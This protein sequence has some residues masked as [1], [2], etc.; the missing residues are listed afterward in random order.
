MKEKALAAQI[1]LASASPRRLELLEQIGVRVIVRAVDIDE[2][3][4]EGESVLS[5]VQRLAMAKA[6]RG[7]E[8]IDNKNEL[9]VLGSD[10]VVEI[11]GMILGKPGSRQQAREMLQQLSARKHTVHTSVAIV[12]REMSLIE[13][14]SSVVLFDTMEESDIERYIATGEADDKAGSYAIQG[15]AAQF[16]KNID[17][18]F[19]GVMG[20]PLYETAQLL[21]Q[22]GIRP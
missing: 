15:I 1:I 12:T 18:S 9:P 7:F 10:T 4:E 17:G 21:K 14:S 20:L 22:C 19:S 11:D 5:Y 13:T 6:Q 2:S 8:T 3:Y 16:I